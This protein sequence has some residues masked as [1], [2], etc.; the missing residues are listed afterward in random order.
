MNV[1]N[2]EQ[3]GNQVQEH[4]QG[5]NEGNSGALSLQGKEPGKLQFSKD[6]TLPGNRPVEASHLNVVSTY[7]SAGGA[8]PVTSG[9][10]K[11]AS[12]ITLSG[13]RPIAA[14]HLHISDSYVVMGNRPV[15]SNAIDDPTTL[16]GFID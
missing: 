2:L 7:K 5:N 8:R 6:I 13:N 1:E 10:F 16:M 11:I 9:T 14:S 15:A 3:N 12:A 4:D